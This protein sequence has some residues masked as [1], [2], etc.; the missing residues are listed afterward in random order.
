MSGLMPRQIFGV[1]GPSAGGH[2]RFCAAF[3]EDSEA[4]GDKAATPAAFIISL[5]EKPDFMSDPPVVI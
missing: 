4:T 3:G 5:R 1:S 2:D